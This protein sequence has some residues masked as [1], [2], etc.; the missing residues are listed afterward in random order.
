MT[1]DSGV[2][3][4]YYTPILLFGLAVYLITRTM[5][6]DEEEFKA[7]EKLEEGAKGKNEKN[8]GIILKY[9]RPFFRRFVTPVIS[10]M[11]NKKKI[12]KKYRQKL[13]AAGLNH[14][15]STEDFY[16]FK[17]FL[18]IGFPI[19]FMVLRTFLETDWP[20]K[21]IPGVA[22]VGF[23][24]PDLWIR[25]TIAKRQEEVMRAMPFAVDMLA[26]S[27]EAGLDFIAAM[28][29][30]VDKARD[31]A[32]VEEFEIL[33]KEIRV[34]AARAE[35]LRN[36]AWR[37]DLL[38][39]S[40]FCATLIAADSVGASIGPI[41]K[42]LS[43]EIREKKSAE[44]EKKGAQAATKL[45]FPMIAFILPAVLLVVLGPVLLDFFTGV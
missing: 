1:E 32:L 14:Y 31:S 3:L 35:A 12:K 6:L 20:M 33:L 39:I 37:I 24:Y 19:L 30:V 26:L 21:Y 5:F 34:G 44:I 2:Q 22:I 11:K 38:P 45:L 17:I 15:L 36:L 9:S 16:A 18:I 41:L 43:R 7:S 27:V 29:K 40:S 25:G 10:S 4:L 13:A 42:A 23:Y 8:Y 28:T